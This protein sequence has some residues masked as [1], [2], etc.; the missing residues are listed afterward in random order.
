[1]IFEDLGAATRQHMLAAFADEESGDPYR[2]PVLSSA[3]RA[4]FPKAMRGA[5][6]N[7]AGNEVTLAAALAR[8][9]LWNP[10][11]TYVRDG[12]AR[13]RKVN[14]R[15]AAERLAVTEFNTWYVAGLAR[16]LKA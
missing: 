12:V 16:K 11:E 15:F 3:G 10:T 9:D 6:T 4:A 5:I 7:S 8:P 1:M 14:P 2:S 13:E